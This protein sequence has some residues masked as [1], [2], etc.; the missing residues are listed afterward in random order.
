MANHSQFH[1]MY[2]VCH[3]SSNTN[4]DITSDKY[5]HKRKIFQL[6]NSKFF[7]LF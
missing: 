2:P 7:L 3:T 1:F 4:T 5:P 6:P